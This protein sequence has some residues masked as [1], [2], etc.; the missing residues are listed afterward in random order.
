MS[1]P[2]VL[3]ASAE[4]L[5]E[6]R[7]QAAVFHSEPGSRERLIHEEIVALHARIELALKD[8]HWLQRACAE[9]VAALAELTRD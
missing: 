7:R 6:G 9:K 5:R 2:P 4:E 1:R 8:L 3:H